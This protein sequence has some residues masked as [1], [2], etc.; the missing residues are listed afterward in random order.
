MSASMLPDRRSK[1]DLHEPVVT[2]SKCSI[3]IRSLVG[4]IVS[5]S[6][7]QS[8]PAMSEEGESEWEGSFDIL[9]GLDQLRKI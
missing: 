8:S 6:M 1:A 2:P 4:Q 3:Q 5:I 9:I 7:R